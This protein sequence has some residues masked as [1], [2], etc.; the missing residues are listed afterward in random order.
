MAIGICEKPKPLHLPFCS[1]GQIWPWINADEC[2]ECAKHREA[3]M[4]ALRARFG[5]GGVPA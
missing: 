5:C 2:E 3:T 1:T 4:R